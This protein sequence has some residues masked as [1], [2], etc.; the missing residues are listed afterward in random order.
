MS[1][2]DYRAYLQQA[3]AMPDWQL[4]NMESAI[5]QPTPYVI[6]DQFAGHYRAP[7]RS[8]ILNRADAR[9]IAEAI[10]QQSATVS[11]GHGPF[12]CRGNQLLDISGGN[13]LSNPPISLCRGLREKKARIG[14]AGP[15]V[16]AVAEVIEFPIDQGSISHAIVYF[17]KEG[18][19]S[20]VKLNLSSRAI[21]ELL[22]TSLRQ[23]EMTSRIDWCTSAPVTLACAVADIV[24]YKPRTATGYDERSGLTLD[25]DNSMDWDWSSSLYRK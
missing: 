19:G 7:F 17:K 14:R 2:A 5:T 25:N 8:F 11:F 13:V 9:A 18:L 4:S 15:Q 21:D 6:K 20:Q 3:Y 24:C 23:L 1:L 22:D 10:N 16:G 12:L